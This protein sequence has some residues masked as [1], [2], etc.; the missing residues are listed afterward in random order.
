MKLRTK[1]GIAFLALTL[2]PLAVLG[3]YQSRTNYTSLMDSG[4]ASLANDLETQKKS[5]IRFFNGSCQDLEFVSQA[6]EVSKLLA[7]YEDED[8]DEIDYWTEALGEVFKTFVENREIFQD[9]RF[10]PRSLQETTVR[11]TYAQGKSSLAEVSPVPE[12]FKKA[13][14][15]T[16]PTAQW[17][18][19]GTLA[20]LWLHYP[21]ENGESAAL[22]STRV[23][24]TAFF[25]L[26]DD[27]EI[28]LL[29]ADTYALLE[30]G[31]SVDPATTMK[32]PA[33][34]N[35][36]INGIGTN[37][38]NIFVYASLPLIKWTEQDLFSIYK[39]R[40][41]AIIMEPIKAS[42]QKLVMICM[43]ALVI[44]VIIGSIITKSITGPVA[45][46]AD[47]AHMIADGN[48]DHRVQL[49]GSTEL[50]ELGDAL[51]SMIDNIKQ[52]RSELMVNQQ[53]VE[54]RVRV[55]NE[56]LEMVGESSQS[57]AETSRGFTSSTTVLS[58]R[59]TDQGNSLATVEEM[60]EDINAR[61]KLNA[62]HATQATDITTNA[63]NIA[64]TGNERMQEMIAAM[65]GIRLSSNKIGQILDVLEDIAGQTNLL[66]LNATIEAARAGEAGKGFAVVAQEV[67]ELAKRSSESVKETASLLEESEKNVAN[68]NDL[69]A[70][71]ANVL[72]DILSSVG[73]VRELNVDIAAASNEQAEGIGK[74]KDGLSNATVDLQNMN[75]IALEIAGDATQL[76]TKTEEL[77]VRLQL[78]L[79]ESEDAVDMKPIDLEPVDDEHLWKEQSLQSS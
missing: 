8:P 7:A 63:Q 23:D 36:G 27:K 74:V 66:A 44:A 9:I 71:T 28:S 72:T 56:I 11:V 1:L 34:D 70:Q 41:K 59:I 18:T 13:L 67:K 64:Q 50:T 61:S 43:A 10:T 32:L 37:P 31:S 52:N 42:L 65:D 20:T 17:G 68:G 12:E 76:S 24:L 38:E 14:A 58:D 39:V 15:G 2:L 60:V 25:A 49:T 73:Q 62:E 21:V 5:F 53:S 16:T 48:L 57:V 69:A 29:R 40:A 79:K 46:A 30:A 19:D 77:V 55:Q 75:G 51:N 3:I 54:L 35:L 6:T 4:K 22:L 33:T 26:C 78:K 45:M 47:A